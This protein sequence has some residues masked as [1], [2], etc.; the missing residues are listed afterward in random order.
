[1]QNLLVGEKRRKKEE[2]IK[3]L[4]MHPYLRMAICER[5]SN[6]VVTI[7]FLRRWLH[8]LFFFPFDLLI[9]SQKIHIM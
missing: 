3:E 1:M 6:S 2:S 4:I 7:K 9:K 8:F 5:F